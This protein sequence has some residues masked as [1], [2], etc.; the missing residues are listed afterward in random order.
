MKSLY[1]LLITTL[2]TVTSYGA[3]KVVPGTGWEGWGES[4]YS[5]TFHN[6]DNIFTPAEIKSSESQVESKLKTIGLDRKDGSSFSIQIYPMFI[7]SSAWTWT[8]PRWNVQP[9]RICE[10]QTKDGKRFSGWVNL[11]PEFSLLWNTRTHKQNIEGTM[12][13]FVSLYNKANSNK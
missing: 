12:D 2:L 5:I 11:L 6:Y 3:D 13:M 10:R 9:R 8:L 7:R 1:Y 4:G